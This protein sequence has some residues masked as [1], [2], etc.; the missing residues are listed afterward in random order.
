MAKKMDGKHYF[1]ANIAPMITNLGAGVV[2]MGALA[3]IQH[4][5]GF[6]GTLL[7]VGMVVEAIIFTL[8]AF[9]PQPV[10]YHWEL[11]YPQLKD[12]VEELDDDV[13]ITGEKKSAVESLDKMFEQANIDKTLIDKLGKSMYSLSEN[14]TKMGEIEQATVASKEFVKATNDYAKSVS[15]HRATVDEHANVLKGVSTETGKLTSSLGVA[16]NAL[17]SVTT[18]GDASKSYHE[19]VQKVTKSIGALNAVYEM[20]L[21][22][23]NNH[24]KTMNKFYT[25]LA[26]AMNSMTEANKEADSFKAEIKKLTSQLASLNGVYGGMLSAM[27]GGNQ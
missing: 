9:A 24:L 6:W 16:A 23:A 5:P 20:E 3:K 2:I 12:D 17:G 7:T 13:E 4:W 14:V 10:E 1:Y 18:M 26:S 22:D 19:T 25:N 27:R 15:A 21:A 8:F 11:V